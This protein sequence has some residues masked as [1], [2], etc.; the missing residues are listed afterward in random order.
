MYQLIHNFFSN[1]E[2]EQVTQNNRERGGGGDD[3]DK[4]T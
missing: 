4:E 2:L 3:N 1:S